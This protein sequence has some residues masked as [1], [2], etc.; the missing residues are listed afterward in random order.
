[1]LITHDRFAA[2]SSAQSALRAILRATC[3]WPAD[4][5]ATAKST[6]N[7]MLAKTAEAADHAPTSAARRK[8]LRDALV[9]ALVLAGMCDIA[10]AHGIANDDL[11]DSLRHASRTISMLGMSF[12]ATAA[13]ND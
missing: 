8:C 4:L 7:N 6:A 5:A 2:Y 9:D 13:V 1:M 12:H 3:A 11:D 10:A